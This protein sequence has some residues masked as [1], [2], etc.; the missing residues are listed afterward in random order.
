[1]SRKHLLNALAQLFFFPSDSNYVSFF[2]LVFANKLCKQVTASKTKQKKSNSNNRILRAEQTTTPCQV[3]FETRTLPYKRKFN[4]MKKKSLHL[5]KQIINIFIR[6]LASGRWPLKIPNSGLHC[7]V[8]KCGKKFYSFFSRSLHIFVH[9]FSFE[10]SNLF[11]HFRSFF[12]RCFQCS[13]IYTHLQQ[14]AV[15]TV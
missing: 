2:L 5:P 4:I 7:F 1:M 10:S 3:I 11:I 8:I 6:L 9:F 15:F 12:G 14:C 13:R